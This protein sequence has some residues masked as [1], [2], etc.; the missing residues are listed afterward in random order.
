MVGAQYLVLGTLTGLG[1]KKGNKYVAN[2]SL[3]M[4][5]VETAEIFLAGRGTGQGNDAME[6]FQNAT[7]EAL[8]GQRGMLT[9]L[10][11]TSKK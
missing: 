7:K 9:M 5:E 4:I 8:Y 2:V 6:A 11:G 10:L 1:A 3:R